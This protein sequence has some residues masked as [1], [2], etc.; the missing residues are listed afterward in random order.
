MTTNKEIWKASS[1]NYLNTLA[2]DVN[3]L[4]EKVARVSN[5]YVNNDFKLDVCADIA[6]A[7]IDYQ[8]ALKHFWKE[9]VRI[10]NEWTEWNEIN[11]K[12][13]E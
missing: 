11:K 3:E 6:Q 4:R 2:S 10:L 7:K 8:K 5:L 1:I 12:E 9:Y 13:V